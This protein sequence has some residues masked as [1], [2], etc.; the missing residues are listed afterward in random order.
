MALIC[1]D[2]IETLLG[3]DLDSDEQSVIELYINFAVGEIEAWLGRP[4]SVQSFEED[5]I[6]DADGRVYL[7]NTP[8]IAV[9]AITVD[10]EA[11]EDDF[12]TV[13]PWGLENVYYRTRGGVVDYWELGDPQRVIDEFY[14]PEIVVEYTAGLDTPEAVNSVIAA[15]VIRKWNERKAQLAKA[16][17]GAENIEQIKVED[18]MIKYENS[19]NFQT[20]SYVANANPMTIF[21]HDVDFNS[22]KRFRKRSIG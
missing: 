21:R 22:I 11:K 5:V 18:Y 6:A 1:V 20:S 2:D 8:V 12:Y 14:E 9:T 10:G 19:S 13:T 4:I 7:S 17:G 3:E 15:G 16:A